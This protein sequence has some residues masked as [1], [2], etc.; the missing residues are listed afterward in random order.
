M[1]FVTEHQ[2]GEHSAAQNLLDVCVCGRDYTRRVQHN[3]NNYFIRMRDMKKYIETLA[4]LMAL[5]CAC[6]C[7]KESAEPTDKGSEKQ[8]S[9]IG[10]IPLTFSVGTSKTVLD[11]STGAINFN[12]GD[13]IS[14]FDGDAKNNEFTNTTPGNNKPSV[15]FQGEVTKEADTYYALYP[16][17]E[18]AG[19][20][21][22]TITN[23]SLPASQNATMNSF[24]P[25][26]NISVGATSSSNLVLMN[27]CS[28]LKIVVEPGESYSKAV[29]TS[30]DGTAM[31]GTINISF[32]VEGNPV[33]GGEITNGSSSVTLTGNMVSATDPTNYYVVVLPKTYTKGFTVRL[34][35]EGQEGAAAMKYTSSSVTIERAKIGNFGHIEAGLL[36]PGVFTVNSE[37]KKVQFARGNLWCNETTSPKTYGFENNQYEIVFGEATPDATSHRTHFFKANYQDSK[38]SNMLFANPDSEINPYK[39]W[40]TLTNDEWS[41]LLGLSTSKRSCTNKYANAVVAGNPGLLIFPDDNKWPDGVTMPTEI[42]KPVYFKSAPQY[43]FE[44][45]SKLEQSGFVFLAGQGRLYRNTSYKY[46]YDNL[47]DSKNGYGYGR[48]VTSDMGNT[49]VKFLNFSHQDT[50]FNPGTL[51]NYGYSIRLVCPVA[52]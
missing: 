16:Y 41:Y 28:L 47:Y 38:T 12:E 6:S 24:D 29:I 51:G 25:N 10:K 37:G 15:T 18:N 1:L 32:D 33:V 45:F 27:V 40:E 5:F 4:I 44:E 35:K 48:Y 9:A 11:P 14:I 52:Q 22:G 3:G 13:K 20:S 49:N 39:G 19:F 21:E 46:V 17:Q 43:T 30:N 36:L 42:N 8:P 50:N 2:D 34:Y 7:S 31:C 26:A 23:V